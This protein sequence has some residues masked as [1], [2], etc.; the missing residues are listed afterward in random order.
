MGHRVMK[1]NLSALDTETIGGYAVIL[2]TEFRTWAAHNFKEC[3]SPIFMDI[4]NQN[5]SSRLM[6]W[7]Q[8]YDSQAILKYLPDDNVNE[9]LDTN[10]TVYADRYKILYIKGKVLRIRDMK[11]KETLSGYDAAQFYS[12]MHLDDAGLKYVNR[13]KYNSIVTEGI[14]TNAALQTD[15]ELFWVFGYHKDEIKHYCKE[16]ASLTQDLGYYLK[17]VII[18]MFGFEISSYSAKTVIGRTLIKNTV[19]KDY[20]KFLLE[21]SPGKLARM[22]YH[23]GIFDCKKRGTFGEC[24]DID[25]SS[26]YPFHQK[27]LPH[28]A[29]GDFIEVTGDEIRDTDV[30]G[31]VWCRFDYPLI[32]YTVDEHYTWDEVHNDEIQLVAADGLRKYYPNGDR[33]Q[34]ITLLEM[35][36]LEKYGYLKDNIGGVVWRHN[37]KKHQYPKPFTWINDVYKLKKQVKE[38]P[39]EGKDSYKYSITKIAMNSAY[40]VTA[41]KKGYAQYRNF[42]YA[43]YITAPTRVQICE[44]LE[45]IGYDRYISIATDG[46]LLEGFVEL[47][48]RFLKTGLGSWDVEHWDKALVIANGIY[49]L[50]KK[51]KKPKIATRGM[52]SFKGDLVELITKN[53]DE[54]SVIPAT[55]H[56]PV[57][58]YQAMRWKRYTKDDMNRFV[59]ITRKLS[60]NTETSKKWG[61]IKTFNDLLQKNY[62]G[63]RF[64]IDEL[65]GE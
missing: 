6:M 32:P 25:I 31:W 45:E 65:E 42:F 56:R 8:G 46:I 59:A 36:F 44:M 62:T 64:T 18:D 30:Y 12:Y 28:W 5:I 50:E 27:D 3:V 49:Q 33:W 16:D 41:Q 60:C 61:D 17:N 29:N 43:S 38:N 52:L 7:N 22:A 4:H 20:P 24:T 35:R 57:T 19:G 55:A 10:N 11:L 26:A 39:K 14:T 47:P 48:E 58:M 40:G 21:S 1:G 53:K 15:K 13:G 23:G 63:T 54:I 34:P 51:G 9:I 2:S 37:P